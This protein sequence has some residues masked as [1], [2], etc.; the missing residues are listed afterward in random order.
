VLARRTD[1]HTKSEQVARQSVFAGTARDQTVSVSTRTLAFMT[2]RPWLLA[3]LF[4]SFYT[5]ANTA[6]QSDGFVATQG[7]PLTQEIR[8]DAGS[9]MEFTWQLWAINATIAALAIAVL[10]VVAI[11]STR[12]RLLCI[13]LCLVASVF[14]WINLGYVSL[15]SR[16][17]PSAF[18][19]AY[20]FPLVYESSSET[21][22]S[23]FYLNIGNGLSCL[24][25]SRRLFFD[26]SESA[27]ASQRQ[28]TLKWFFVVLWTLL[29]FRLN[30]PFVLFGQGYGGFPLHYQSACGYFRCEHVGWVAVVINVV[31][32]LGALYLSCPYFKSTRSL[33]CGVGTCLWVWG[34]LGSWHRWYS[35]LGVAYDRLQFGF[36]LPVQSFHRSWLGFA[37]SALGELRRRCVMPG[38]RRQTRSEMGKASSLTAF[39][40]IITD[41]FS[42]ED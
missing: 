18:D 12:Q 30:S 33:I 11:R 24:V 38:F 32:G 19:Y 35:S 13:V 31:S 36:S 39:A 7:F 29:F 2:R 4:G 21:R 5:W 27:D 14:T 8:G 40:C 22:P 16:F 34:S 42:W 26:D 20:G 6:Y 37:A 10:C 41:T 15:W 9:L 25:L 1:G 23:F 28:T 17:F 3:I